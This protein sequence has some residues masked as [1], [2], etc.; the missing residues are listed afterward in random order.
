MPRNRV[1]CGWTRPQ[2]VSRGVECF[3]SIIGSMQIGRTGGECGGARLSSL[4]VRRKFSNSR[5]SR[6]FALKLQRSRR[7]AYGC[8]YPPCRYRLPKAHEFHPLRC[9]GHRCSRRVESAVRPCCARRRCNRRRLQT[10][11]AL[12]AVRVP[13]VYAVAPATALRKLRRSRRSLARSP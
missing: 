1:W 11:R 6:S 2:Q 13:L 4:H 8:A 10:V 12:N 5:K 7:T 3:K 9:P